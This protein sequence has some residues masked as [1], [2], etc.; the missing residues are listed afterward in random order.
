[1]MFD[2]D[3][4]LSICEK[5]GVDHSETTDSPMI[6]IEEDSTDC[7]LDKIKSEI[8]QLDYDI[9]YIDY[10]YNDMT[11]TEE[12]H[13]ICREEVLRIIDKYREESKE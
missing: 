9:D 2:K 4:F 13:T 3:L 1:M 10:D 11:Q 8:I 12:I 6:K 7:I 5:Y